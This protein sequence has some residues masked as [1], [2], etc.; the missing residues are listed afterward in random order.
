MSY[1]TTAEVRGLGKGRHGDR[2]LSE[3]T[4]R[5][6]LTTEVSRYARNALDEIVALPAFDGIAGGGF[7]GDG[8]GLRPLMSAVA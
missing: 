8:L 1:A 5:E 6:S 4:T 7:R 3:L 2:Q